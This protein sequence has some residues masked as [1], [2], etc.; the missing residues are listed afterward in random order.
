[1]TPLHRLHRDDTGMV[2][3]IIIIWVLMVALLGIVALDTASVV[4]ATFRVS[5][6]AATAATTGATAY[7]AAGDVSKACDA[8]RN[9]IEAD[10]SSVRIPKSFCKIDTETGRVTIVVK[11]QADTIVAGRLSFTEHL[12]V[13]VGKET[14]G[15]SML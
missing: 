3:K 14:A 11:K 2:G 1:M 8:A 13:V 7:R 12:T 4:F 5:D 6:I 9:T 15:P 10:D